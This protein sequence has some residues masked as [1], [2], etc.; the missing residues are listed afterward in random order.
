MTELVHRIKIFVYRLVRSEP[1]YLLLKP[2]QGLEALWGPIHAPLGFGEKLEPAARRQAREA[3]GL[4]PP[5]PVIDLEMPE[6]WTVGD[7]EII[8][9][10]FG[11]QSLSN[12]D[13]AQ[14]ERHWATY[15]WAEFADA[16]PSLG[17]DADRAAIMRLHTL[18][19]AA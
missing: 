10:T 8:E 17:F 15:R 9:W 18:L 12:P 13:P 19:G 2:D 3:A 6:R 5:G 1:D 11:I 7:E 4:M 14:L 16:Y